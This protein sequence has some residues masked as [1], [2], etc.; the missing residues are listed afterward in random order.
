VAAAAAAAAAAAVVKPLVCVLMCVHVC[1]YVYV[2]VCAHQGMC[3]V[4]V[5]AAT[6]AALHAVAA[7]A[8]A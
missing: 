6:A 2:C 7:A 4:Y 1:V 8:A 5:G 3:G